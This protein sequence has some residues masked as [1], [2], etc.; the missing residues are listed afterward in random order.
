MDYAIFVTFMTTLFFIAKF[1]IIFT[2][3]FTI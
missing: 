3:V 1:N 2:F